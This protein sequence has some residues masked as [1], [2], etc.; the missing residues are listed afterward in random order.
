MRGLINYVI[1]MT[2]LYILLPYSILMSNDTYTADSSIRTRRYTP[3]SKRWSTLIY[4]R[5]YVF[6]VITSILCRMWKPISQIESNWQEYK[7]RVKQNRRLANATQAARK[8]QSRCETTQRKTR[9]SHIMR[10]R[11]SQVTANDAVAFETTNSEGEKIHINTVKFD[12]DSAKVGIDNRCSA[13]ISHDISD[14]DGPI[15]KVNRAIKGFGGE[16]VLNVYQGTI[17]WKWADNQGRIH[18]FRIPNSYYVPDGQCR[19]LS[20]QHWA[21]SQAGN[22]TKLLRQ[23]GETT[24][25]DKCVLF[26]NDGQNSLDVQMGERDNVATFYLAPGYNKF[27]LFCERCEINYTE[28]QET[29]LVAASTLI[30]DD[31]NNDDALPPKQPRRLWSRLTGLPI[32]RQ[33]EAKERRL[34]EDDPVHTHFNLNGPTSTQQPT[35]PVVIEEEEDRQPTTAA[36]QLL[37]YHHRFGHI[38]FAKLQNMARQNILP[39]HLANITPPACTACLFA[40]ATRRQ[41]RNKRRKDWTERQSAMR[42]GDVISVDQLVSPT[43]GFIGQLTGTLTKKRY[44]YATVYVDQYSG[45]GYV[46]LQKTSDAQETIQGKKAF[47]AYCMQHGVT[48]KAYHADN[49]IFRANKWVDECRQNHQTLTFAGVNAHHSNGL[50]ERRIRS[51]QDLARAMMIHQ[52]RRWKMAATVNLW[53]FAIRMANDAINE[54][55]NSRDKDARS[56]LQIFSGS[57][58]ETNAKHWIPF[59]CPAYVLADPLQTGRGIYNKWEYRSRVGIYLGRSPNHG[60]NVA[61]VLDRTTGLVSPQFHVTFDPGFHTVKQDEFDTKWQAKAGF[62]H[63]PKTKRKRQEKT[64]SMYAL[65]RPMPEQEGAHSEKKRRMS[66]VPKE[67]EKQVESPTLAED[68]TKLQQSTDDSQSAQK[69]KEE[70]PT[71]SKKSDTAEEPQNFSN[72]AERVIHSMAAELSKATADNIEG[73]IYSYQAMFPNYAGLPE[74]DPLSIY[75][76]TA[77]PDTMYMHQAMKQP[78][79]HEFRKAMQKEW[80]DQLGN[81]NFS[82]VRRTEVP[83]DATILPT[84]WQMRRKRDIRTRRIKKYKARLNIDGSRMRYGQHYD[85]TYA[86]VASWNSIRTLLIMT[87]LHGWHTKQIDYVLAFPQ[88]PVERQIF[89]EI[90]KGFQIKEGQTKDYVLELHRNVYGQ[91]QAGRVWNKYLTDI[92][93][94]KVGFKQSRVDECVFYRGSVMYVLYTDDSILAGPDQKEIDKAIEDIKAADLDITIEGDLQDFLGVNIDRRSDGT[95]RLTQPHL[96]DQI[97][98]DLKMQENT[99][100]TK[101]PAASSKILSRHSDSVDFDNSFHYRSVIGKLNY[102]E[103]GSRPDIAYITHQCARFSTCPKKEHA[104]A[105][106]WLARYLKGTRD[107]GMILKPDKDRGLEVFVDADFAG[108]WDV[109]EHQDR[110][111][112]RSRHGYFI[113]YAGVPILW[114]SQLQSEIALSSTESEYTGL[115][116]ALRDAIPIMNLF[117]EMIEEGMPVSSSKAKVHCKVFEDNSGALEIAKVAKYRPRTKHLNCRLHHFRSYVDGTKEISI[118]KIDTLDQP[119]DILTKPLNEDGIRRHRETMM[120][121]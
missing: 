20:P 28:S 49:G 107:K 73:E 1:S 26:W 103:K 37:R 102:L 9:R 57:D 60:R 114:K 30:S 27:D 36:A 43:A 56:P 78:D 10:E 82:V 84:V 4:L 39:R 74:Q 91:K 87:A 48:V 81:G 51:L 113:M 110:D 15:R 121:W 90:P 7:H 5:S 24:Y 33:Q 72:P 12:T 118:H 58:I 67:P 50:A 120:G 108:N 104:D 106:R 62:L 115:S 14:F 116:Y 79:A 35:P 11:Y 55:P 88:A 96:V 34:N 31:E 86:P 40:K 80:D 16:R 61:L 98:E 19:L 54:S 44:K 109:K 99:K 94:N 119:A 6:S 47:E 97:L 52:N 17:I 59:G 101:I 71:A 68:D 117:K 75:K 23:Y 22:S 100:P 89:M 77:D 45:L 2:I 66:G 13:C 76:A 3:K 63:D 41:W 53:P 69:Q 92:L 8:M 46:Y 83:K 111:T 85:Q 32:G 18:K 42:P 64:Q 70:N 25:A 65:K 93:V 112:A 29:P 21:R 95:I 38:S 105:I